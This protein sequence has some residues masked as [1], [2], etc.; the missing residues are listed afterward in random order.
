M[1]EYLTYVWRPVPGTRHAFPFAATKLAHDQIAI[2]YCGVEVEAAKLH[3]L[4][5]M[6]WILEPTCMD[7][8]RHLAENPP[9]R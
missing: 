3:G 7:C 4:D 1:L 9:G 5:E 6:A 8:W 2:A